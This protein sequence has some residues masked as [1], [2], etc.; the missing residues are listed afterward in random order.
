MKEIINEVVCFGCKNLINYPKCKAFNQI[1]ESI[2][3]GDSNHLIPESDQD[4]DIVFEPK[5]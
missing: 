5:E 4:N 2:R 3:N 1:P